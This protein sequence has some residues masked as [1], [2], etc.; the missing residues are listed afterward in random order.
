[1]NVIAV[2][3][4]VVITVILGI[5]CRKEKILS[6]SDID[7]AKKIAVNITLPAVS[8]SAYLNTEYSFRNLLIPLWVLICCCLMLAMGF[9]A[10][11]LIRSN[12]RMLPFL[13]SGFEGGMIGF[14]LYPILHDNMGPFSLLIM[15]N[16][17]YV[18]T[19]FKIL[20]SGAK[21]KK[22]VF[23]EAVR[24]PSLWA[25]FIGILLSSTG[26]YQAMAPSGAKDVL[27]SV[28]TFVSKSTGFLILLSIGYDLDFGAIDWR[29]ACTAFFCRTV[30]CG[31]LLAATLFLN[32]T[33][34]GSSIPTDAAILM[35]ILPAP[36]VIKVFAADG[37][38]HAGLS[39]ALSLMTFFTLIVF[40]L[41]SAAL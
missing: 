32:R 22:A 30:I 6:A 24:S 1:M 8:L 13:C 34:F 12:D 38:H 9:G 40:V 19:I 4:P 5:I 18:F 16:V 31:I 26:L 7:S 35:F 29:E 15:G 39:S 27:D 17:F 36:Y 33:V 37:D 23:Q 20:L 14:S 11:K 2:I 41:L 28:L 10:K 25:L 3:L 21:G